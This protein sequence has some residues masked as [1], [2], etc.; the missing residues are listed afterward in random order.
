MVSSSGLHTNK[1]EYMD[2]H[3]TYICK[4][5]D[6]NKRIIKKEGLERWSKVKNA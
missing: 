5:D 2:R 1:Y 4:K 3:N 6:K